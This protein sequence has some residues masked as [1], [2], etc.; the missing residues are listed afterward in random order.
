MGEQ[1][2]KEPRC[3]KVSQ[4]HHTCSPLVTAIQVS[5]AFAGLWHP[6]NVNLPPSGIILCNIINLCVFKSSNQGSVTLS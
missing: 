6:Y 4:S 3:L 1:K 5:L 2:E